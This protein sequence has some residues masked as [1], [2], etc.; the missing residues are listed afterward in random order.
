MITNCNGI[1]LWCWLHCL[2]LCSATTT[3]C[4]MPGQE[5]TT[6]NIARVSEDRVIGRPRHTYMHTSAHLQTCPPRCIYNFLVTYPHV[7]TYVCMHVDTH[8]Y[9]RTYL[10]WHTTYIRTYKFSMNLHILGW[11]TGLQRQLSLCLWL[12]AY[13]RICLPSS[14]HGIYDTRRRLLLHALYGV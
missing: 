8:T 11:Y 2:V 7:H 10:Q 6:S 12:Y 13:I 9:S 14:W 4:W 5:G 1:V 3:C